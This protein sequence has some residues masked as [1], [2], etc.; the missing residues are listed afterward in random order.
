MSAETKPDLQKVKILFENFRGGRSGKERLPENLWEQ[1][2]TLLEY[3]PFRV[4]CR[5]LRLKPDYLRQRAAAMQQGRTEKFKLHRP[6]KKPRR[7]PEQEFLH[8]TAH[9]LSTVPS[10]TQLLAPTS[11]CRVMIER[12]DGSR[13][14]LTVPLDWSCIET[15]CASFLRG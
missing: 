2:I 6:A 15:L 9:E 10:Q 4:V 8:L 3:Y 12:T 14:Q 7:K 11:A 1:A 13:L 5:Q